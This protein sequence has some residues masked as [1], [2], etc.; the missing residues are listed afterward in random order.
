MGAAIKWECMKD[1]E[2]LHPGTK[3]ST[4]MTTPRAEGLRGGNGVTETR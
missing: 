1:G 4:I 2:V 3:S